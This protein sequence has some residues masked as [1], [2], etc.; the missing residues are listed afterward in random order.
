MSAAERDIRLA[1]FG[2]QDYPPRVQFYDHSPHDPELSEKSGRPR[3][4]EVLYIKLKPTH[5]DL[6]VRDVVSYPAKEAD[7]LEYPVQWA[8]YQKKQTEITEFKP[9]LQAIPGMRISAF[10]ELQALEIYDCGALA[11]YK[12]ELDEIDYLRDIAKRIMEVSDEARNLRDERQAVQEATDRQQHD[13]AHL[14][15]SGPGRLSEVI[16]RQI[17]PGEQGG[18]KSQSKA[19]SG[20][21]ERGQE[22]FQ[23]NFEVST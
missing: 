7:K 5:P 3:F 10:N 1:L 11:E 20:Q 4:R 18:E 12:G 16:D 6:T 23:Y 2:K 19:G 9:P 8:E 14:F 17:S 22:I 13:S 15:R 21:K